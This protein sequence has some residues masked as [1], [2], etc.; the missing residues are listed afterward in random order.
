M[1]VF[2]KG[3]RAGEGGA[4]PLMQTEPA[5]TAAPQQ[6]IATVFAALVL[7]IFLASLDQTIVSTALP[8]IVGDLGGLAHLS[9]VVTAYLLATTI[10]GPVYGKLGDLYGRKAVLQAAILLFLA[11]SALCGFARNMPELVAFRALQG[12]GGG[13]LMVTTMAIVGDLVPPRERGRYQGIFGAVFGVSAVLGP[14]LGGFFVD[15]LSWRWI[16]YINLPT[17]LVALV[18]IGVVFRAAASRQRRRIDVAGAVLLAG[19]LG[20]LILFTSFGGTVLAWRSP[21][22]LGLLAACVLLTAALLIVE[23][24]TTEPIL[25]LGLF[26]DRV[27]S[28]AN[29]VSLV[30]GLAMF[31]SV[32]YLPLYLQVV[33]G[34]S[35]TESGLQLAPMMGGM[36]V[37]SIASGRLISRFGRYKLFPIAGTAIMTVALGLLSRLGVESSLVAASL[38]AA[39]LGL[40]LG[41]VMQVLILAVQNTVSYTHLGVA[42]STATLFRS[43]GGSVGVSLFGAIF[44]NLLQQNL[45]GSIPPGVELP[46]ATNPQALLALPAALRTAYLSAFAAALHPVFLVAAAIGALAFA[47]TWLLR[48]RPLRGAVPD[49]G[50][51]KGFAMPR[52]ASSLDELALIVSRLAERENRWRVYAGLAQRAGLDL[53]EAELWT[54]ARLGERG[55]RGMAALADEL[56]LSIRDLREPLRGLRARGM[57]ESRVDGMLALTRHGRAGRDRLVRARRE[58]LSEILERWR[59]EEHEDVRRLLDRLAEALVG[60][61]PRPRPASSGAGSS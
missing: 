10:V 5:A 20:T 9:W 43:I 47:L 29:A 4:R 33:K 14:L 57:V 50:I 54:L 55:A 45:A 53:P 19:A 1:D 48:E 60:E 30:V 8:T 28:V 39:L 3:M 59:P 32:T 40:G 37:S 34:A 24:R 41:M 16:F 46:T 38:A 35:P 27:F 31:G 61:V 15:T 7:V 52:D 17:G 2:S 26:R 58:A 42:T 25:P 18:V 56:G 12:I 23:S 49:E 13:G 6:R 11:G 51:G 36:L 22:S 21:A 44:A